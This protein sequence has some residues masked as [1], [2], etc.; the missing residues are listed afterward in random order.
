MGAYVDLAT[1]VFFQ[2]G[3]FA[4]AARS[5]R[6]ELRCTYT[7]SLEATEAKGIADQVTRNI[8]ELEATDA[9]V[10]A[11]PS[12]STSEAEA[13]PSDDY[14][15]PVAALMVHAELPYGLHR[16]STLVIN[17][18]QTLMRAID[19]HA[20]K[21]EGAESGTVGCVSSVT[22]CVRVVNGCFDL[23]C[24]TLFLRSFCDCLRYSDA[25]MRAIAKSTGAIAGYSP[26]MSQE[27]LR[28]A[29]C[30]LVVRRSLF[31]DLIHHLTCTALEVLVPTTHSSFWCVAV[32]QAGARSP[33][34]KMPSLL[35][36]H[37]APLVLMDR[38][39][40]CAWRL[41]LLEVLVGYCIP[42]RRTMLAIKMC[43]EVYTRTSRCVRF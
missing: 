15:I 18:V 3:Q 11:E 21:L 33:G 25:E 34:S 41:R 35:P 24:F 14:N 4:Q 32:T 1:S 29:Y 26:D 17:R 31:A 27:R 36:D 42:A 6:E 43:Q 9:Q 5:I 10:D 16:D 28:D 22:C 30:A 19:A 13:S 7:R 40:C 12:S 38:V 23:F 20:A 8:A 37:F 39:Q 2:L